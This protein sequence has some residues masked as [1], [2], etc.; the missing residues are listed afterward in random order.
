MIS[1]TPVV[2][3]VSTAIPGAYP[4]YQ[5]SS[6]QKTVRLSLQRRYDKRLSKWGSIGGKSKAAAIGGVVEGR[7]EESAGVCQESAVGDSGG[8]E[9][10]SVAGGGGTE[11]DETQHSVSVGEEEI[12]LDRCS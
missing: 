7:C 5:I 6:K 11:G 10:A 8:E 3:D 9:V 2:F 12:G 4:D 1:R